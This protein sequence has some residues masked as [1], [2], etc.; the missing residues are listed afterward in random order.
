M[1][2]AFARHLYLPAICLIILEVT[3]Y[4]ALYSAPYRLHHLAEPVRLQVEW[5]VG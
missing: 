5:R 1:N 3:G 4:E 2:N